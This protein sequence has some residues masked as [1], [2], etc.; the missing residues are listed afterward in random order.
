MTTQNSKFTVF[1]NPRGAWNFTLREEARLA[2]F[3]NN[4]QDNIRSKKDQVK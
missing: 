1:F 2:V 3:Q 4:F